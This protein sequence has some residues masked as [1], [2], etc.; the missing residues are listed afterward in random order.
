MQ[1][2]RWNSVLRWGT[3][4]APW[5][6]NLDQYSKSRFTRLLVD[7]EYCIK[8]SR[9]YSKSIN[10]KSSSSTVNLSTTIAS[11]NNEIQLSACHCSRCLLQIVNAIDWGIMC[12]E[13]NFGNSKPLTSSLSLEILQ[14]T[15]VARTSSGTTK[16]APSS[17]IP[18]PGA[19]SLRKCLSA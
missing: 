13:P 10:N 4:S 1:C 15:S 7:F 14:S 19:P 8:G 9:I 16:S 2:R 12:T 18:S 5:I 17:S 3:V 6:N 11:F